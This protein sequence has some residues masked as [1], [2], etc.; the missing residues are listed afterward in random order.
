MG[1]FFSNVEKERSKDLENEIKRNLEIIESQ[2]L[3]Y[4]SEKDKDGIISFVIDNNILKKDIV[5][6]TRDG[7]GYTIWYY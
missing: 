5:N 7:Y 1:N 4:K 3:K 2:C 6:I